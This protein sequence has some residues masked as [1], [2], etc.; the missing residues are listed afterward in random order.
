MAF[1]APEVNQVSADTTPVGIRYLLHSD[2]VKS[3]FGDC[4]L[5]GMQEVAQLETVGL[6]RGSERQPGQHGGL[7]CPSLF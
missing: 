2:K 1:V 6:L 4:Q 3:Y 7:P 5:C